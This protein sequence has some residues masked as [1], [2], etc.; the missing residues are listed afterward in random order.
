MAD[1]NT[2]DDLMDLDPLEL[3]A[4]NIDAII[5]HHRKARANAASGIKAK[6][7]KGPSIDISSVM[8]NLLSGGG[9]GTIPAPPAGK[10]RR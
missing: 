6:R 10:M 7:E 1:T 3:T 2:L 4:E 9:K 5:A 8:S